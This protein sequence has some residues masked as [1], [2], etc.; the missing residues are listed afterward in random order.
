MLSDL[1]LPR[2]VHACLQ[3][4]TAGLHE[5]TVTIA[6]ATHDQSS[7]II[8]PSVSRTHLVTIVYPMASRPE[9]VGKL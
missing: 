2:R 7:S 1:V 9:P 8:N 3:E 4:F 5:Q 6:M